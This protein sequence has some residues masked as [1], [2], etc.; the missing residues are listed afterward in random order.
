MLIWSIF[1]PKSVTNAGTKIVEWNSTISE[2][3]IFTRIVL[4]SLNSRYHYWRST[5]NESLVI[6]SKNT[7]ETHRSKL[8]KTKNSLQQ[9]SCLRENS[10]VPPNLQKDDEII[11]EEIRN[12]KERDT[13]LVIKK[14]IHKALQQWKKTRIVRLDSWVFFLW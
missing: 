1:I 3:G 10:Q 6:I 13:R 9:H 12:L 7:Q 2:N 5:T 8:L 11:E 14:R 4:I